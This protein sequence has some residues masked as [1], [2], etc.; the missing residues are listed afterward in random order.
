MIARELTEFFA[1]FGDGSRASSAASRRSSRTST[2]RTGARAG[3]RSASTTSPTARTRRSAARSPRTRAGARP[4]TRAPPS[5]TRTT[6]RRSSS[7]AATSTSTAG[8][9]RR[10]ATSSRSACGRPCATCAALVAADRRYMRG[11]G[12]VAGR[13]PLDGALARAPRRPQG[14]LGARLA[15]RTALPARRPARAL[16]R[17]P[18][19]NARAAPRPPRAAAARARAAAPSIRAY[20]GI[21][22]A[23]HD[24]PAPLLEPYP[25]MA[26]RERLHIAFVD[27]D[28]RHRLRRPQHHL[29]A[30]AAA[31]ADGPHLLDLGPRPVRPPPARRR[32]R[33]AARDPGARSRR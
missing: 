31:R 20:E 9:A 28:V 2:P 18:R 6:T 10:S 4:T 11:R 1:T 33:P 32:R 7:C 17:G 26:D 29:P 12:R 16:A 30:R 21:A 5:C 25:G 27:P 8:C 22:R 14:V 24:G 15:R 13:A 19:P 3:R 23:L